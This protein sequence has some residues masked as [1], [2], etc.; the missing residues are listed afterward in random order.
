MPDPRT[1]SD[2]SGRMFTWG[3]LT[4]VGLIAFALY[5]QHVKQLDPCP[6]CVVQRLGFILVGL[7]GL[8]GALHR[9]AAIGTTIYSAIGLVAAAAGAAAGTYHV[10]LQSDPA[11]A[12]KCVGSPVERILD[13]LELGRMIPPLLQYDGPCTLKPWSL[14]GLSIPEWSLTWFVILA[15]AFVAIPFVANRQ[16]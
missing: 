6:W 9:P 13:Q 1:I 3:F 11:R 10:W 14:L 15:I 5:L 2:R 8:V 4:C 16:S 12:A 7:I